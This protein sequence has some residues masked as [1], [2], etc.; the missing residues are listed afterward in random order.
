MG[1][2]RISYTVDG[3]IA[4]V[5]LNRPPVNALTHK[6]LDAFI[7]IITEADKDDGVRVIVITGAGDKTFCAGADVNIALGGGKHEERSA[8]FVEQHKEELKSKSYDYLLWSPEDR[9]KEVIRRF[10]MEGFP[11]HHIE[12]LQRIN[13]PT[14]AAVNGAAS[15]LGCEIACACDMRIVSEKA[16]FRWPFVG[17]QGATPE[18]AH[19]LLPRLVGLAKAYELILT[20]DII[21]AKEADKI[22]LVNR[23]VPHE[24]LMSATMELASKLANRPPLAVKLAKEGIRWGIE[25]PAEKN[26][27][28]GNLAW[29]FCMG[30]ADHR[31]AVEAFLQ[32]REPVYKGK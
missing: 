15:G 31:E 29:E 9:L 22:G 3:K 10:L 21:D 5:T 11:L 26:K 1:S 19:W 2:E 32:K 25:I 30:T 13:T 17:T 7:D 12:L 28:W 20:S 23:V 16:R 14:I 18:I 27:R 8:E 24:Q 6:D 4:T